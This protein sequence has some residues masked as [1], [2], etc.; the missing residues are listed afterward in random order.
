ML[1]LNVNRHS[2][3][4]TSRPG[5]LP[6]IRFTILPP[7]KFV[8]TRV[9]YRVDQENPAYFEGIIFKQ[10]GNRDDNNV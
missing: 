9:H 7:N 6:R 4:I 5:K 1:R 8:Y 2:V 10:E 3:I